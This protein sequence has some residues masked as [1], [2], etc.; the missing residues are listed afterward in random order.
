MLL[1]HPL[2][3]RTNRQQ[4]EAMSASTI[5]A[6]IAG[7]LLEKAFETGGEQ[8]LARLIRGRTEKA[9]A[10]LLKRMRRGDLVL[11]IT[12]DDFASVLFTFLRAAEEGAARR[13]LELMAD[14]LVNA[15]AEP[16]FAPNEFRRH[17]RHLAELSRAEALA[18]AVMVKAPELAPDP[19]DPWKPLV[20]YATRAAGPFQNAEDFR[21]AC[22]G[23]MRTGWVQPI[24]LYGSMGYGPTVMLKSISRLIDVDGAILRAEAEGVER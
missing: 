8:I 14:Y 4:S 19:K 22:T 23:L 17:S 16:D 24:S 10:I 3:G 12:E 2:A 18:V 5:T 7:K 15:A 13:N 21:A 6:L 11:P 20:D 9:R 1:R